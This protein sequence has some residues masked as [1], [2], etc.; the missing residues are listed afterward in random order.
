MIEEEELI[1]KNVQEVCL[2]MLFY[3]LARIFTSGTR[4][5]KS[6]KNKRRNPRKLIKA[7]YQTVHWFDRLGD[8][9][10]TEGINNHQETLKK[11]VQLI[12]SV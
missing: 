5:K 4:E 2:L 10:G 12:R 7:Q 8:K 9:K 6:K 1:T 3:L 11:N